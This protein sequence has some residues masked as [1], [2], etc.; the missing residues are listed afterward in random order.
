MC[1]W[2]IILFLSCFW[3]S[4]DALE[5][6]QHT[7]KLPLALE[8]KVYAVDILPQPGIELLAQIKH[9]QQ[10]RFALYQWQSKQTITQRGTIIIQPEWLFFDYGKLQSQRIGIYFLTKDQLLRYNIE[11]TNT[12]K[13]LDLHSIYQQQ[14]HSRFTKMDFIQDLNQDGIDDIIIAD[15]QGYHLWLQDT[16]GQLHYQFIAMPA[17][18]RVFGERNIPSY[19]PYPLY[20]I[21]I[22][23][24]KKPDIVFYKDNV[25]WGYIQTPKGFAK[26]AI[27]IPL[28]FQLE[29]SDWQERI[30]SS[31]ERPDQSNLAFSSLQALVDLDGDQIVDIIAQKTTSKGVFNK[32]SAYQIYFGK[33]RNQQLYFDKT[34][35]HSVKS[36]GVQFDLVLKDIFN[37]QRLTM[38]NSSMLITLRKVMQALFTKKIDV[39]IIFY[40]LDKHRHYQATI[41]KSINVSFDFKTGYSSYPVNQLADL[42]N[43]GKLDLLLQE[44][45]K[46]LAIYLNQDNKKSWKKAKVKLTLAL[47]KSGESLFI[48]DVNQDT[49]QDIVVYYGKADG[50]KQ[51]QII[52]LL[53]QQ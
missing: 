30:R 38:I 23:K 16:Q 11:T 41:E 22:N 24:D 34:P 48:Q 49:K 18:M 21:D 51:Q 46:V 35:H 13:V 10:T 27:T 14:Q 3:H 52:R 7:L 6:T 20:N 36:D 9:K 15:F 47:P 5:F 43:D 28:P 37:Q 32:K 45:T 40:N 50:K 29:E 53:L 26:E 17:M 42:N 1:R 12:E 25:L 33:W 2:N 19:Y 44:K 39:D 8:G 31:D 4:V